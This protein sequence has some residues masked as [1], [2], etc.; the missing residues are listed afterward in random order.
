M[1]TTAIAVHI[2]DLIILALA[3][4]LCLL[5]GKA[6]QDNY[7]NYSVAVAAHEMKELRVL[8]SDGLQLGSSL[9]MYN[10]LINESVQRGEIAAATRLFED[11]A[12]AG[13][14]ARPAA[15]LRTV[16]HAPR[17]PCC[18]LLCSVVARGRPAACACLPH[19]PPGVCRGTWAPRVPPSVFNNA[20]PLCRAPPRSAVK[21]D[22]V[23]YNTIINAFA[24]S[25]DVG[26]QGATDTG[27]GGLT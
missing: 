23:T 5:I 26:A 27:L 14:C 8:G 7:V 18:A 15:C 13:R 9:A 25:G 22:K 4:K 24:R 20:A 16:T 1:T 2:P 17:R 21:P 3:N 6:I 10:A 11:M 12:G 19:N